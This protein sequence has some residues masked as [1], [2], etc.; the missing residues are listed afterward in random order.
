MIFITILLP[1]YNM[2]NTYQYYPWIYVIQK[3]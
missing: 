2:W 1:T 3:C